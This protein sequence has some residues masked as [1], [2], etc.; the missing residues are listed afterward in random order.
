MESMEKAMEGVSSPSGRKSVGSSTGSGRKSVLSG[1]R[2]SLAVTAAALF[3]GLRR[4]SVET[5]TSDPKALP[6][7]EE[8]SALPLGREQSPKL[9]AAIA[10]I[11]H[12]EGDYVTALRT[13]TTGYMPR[14]TPALEGDER[15]VIFSNAE[16]ILGVHIEGSPLGRVVPY[17]QDQISTLVPN[18]KGS[19]DQS[20]NQ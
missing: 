15:S 20:I 5:S 1:R 2:N 12:T 4:R 6:D 17:R 7:P 9:V 18:T 13:L 10:E 8:A 14:L 16:T 19:I 3:G 11:V